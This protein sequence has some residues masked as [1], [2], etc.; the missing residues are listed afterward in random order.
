DDTYRITVEDDGAGIDLERIKAVLRRQKHP[1]ADQLD[2]L[3]INDAIRIIFHS[4]FSSA[5]NVSTVAGRGIGMD[6]VRRLVRQ[7]HGKI[8]VTNRPGR[9]LAVALIIPTEAIGKQG[10]ADESVN[11]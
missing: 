8:S 2:Q 4:G 1:D 6:A 5:E 11:N 7:Y 3:Q 9:G 10:A